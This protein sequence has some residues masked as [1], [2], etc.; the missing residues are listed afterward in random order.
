MQ[1]LPLEQREMIVLDDAGQYPD[2]PCGPGW[3]VVSRNERY[4]SLGAKRNAAVDLISPDTEAIAIA[5]DDD[6]YLPDWLAACANALENAEWTQARQILEWTPDLN[7]QRCAS[8]HV[9]NPGSCAYHGAWAYR[10]RAFDRAGRYP[11]VGEE[12]NP[13]ANKMTDLFGFSADTIC[14]MFPDPWYAYSRGKMTGMLKSNNPY[15][16]SDT[17]Q[18]LVRQRERDFHSKA[19]ENIGK[20]HDAIQPVAKI[21]VEW[22]RDYLAIPIPKTLKPRVW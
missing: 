3:R 22:D 5:D 7:W 17:Y 15:H 2:Q 18:Q 19:W 20:G 12:D 21:P 1:T 10:L 8:F 6:M 14:P 16:V 9:S 11:E 4:P 13:L